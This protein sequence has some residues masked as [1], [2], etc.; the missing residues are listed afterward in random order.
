MDEYSAIEE[1]KRDF[2]FISMR[3]KRL[4]QRFMDQ[5]VIAMSA[6]FKYELSAFARGMHTAHHLSLL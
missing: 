2:V 4:R 1:N 6:H 5:A 3:L